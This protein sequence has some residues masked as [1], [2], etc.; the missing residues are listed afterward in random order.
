MR[1]QVIIDTIAIQSEI[2]IDTGRPACSLERLVERHFGVDRAGY[3]VASVRWIALN[4][5]GSGA[6]VASSGR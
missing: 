5:W 2:H 3:I 1:G 6:N 4:S